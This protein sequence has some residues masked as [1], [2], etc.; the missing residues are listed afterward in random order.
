M[1]LPPSSSS[2][3]G[4]RRTRPFDA[5]RHQIRDRPSRR[6]EAGSRRRARRPSSRGNCPALIDITVPILT[7][8]S[9]HQLQ[10]QELLEMAANAILYQRDT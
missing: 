3:C 2:A 9:E 6:S 5:I 1:G 4:R 7:E 10:L 8:K